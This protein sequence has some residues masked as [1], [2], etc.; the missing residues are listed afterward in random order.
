MA[1]NTNVHS[2]ATGIIDEEKSIKHSRLSQKIEEAITDP[3][4]SQVSRMLRI[5]SADD[6][7]CPASDD[8]TPR[9]RQARTSASKL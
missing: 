9:Q 3:S 5:S 6:L 7:G 1:A 4:K 2:D 8:D